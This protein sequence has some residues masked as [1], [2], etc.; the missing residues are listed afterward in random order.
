MYSQNEVLV[1]DGHRIGLVA[2][3]PIYE[4][5]DMDGIRF[6]PVGYH[7]L[8]LPD[9]NREALY[10]KAVRSEIIR[11]S[12]FTEYTG[13][14]YKDAFIL[15]HNILMS[16]NDSPELMH[17]IEDSVERMV[18]TKYTNFIASKHIDE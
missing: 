5:I 8:Q 1:I 12:G 7:L 14:E 3:S 10:E 16:A 11:H 15:Q 9:T 6:N 4:P 2:N 13:N 18:L 17:F